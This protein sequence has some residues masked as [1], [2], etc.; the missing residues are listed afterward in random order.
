MVKALAVTKEK[1]NATKAIVA[2]CALGWNLAETASTP[3]YYE[4]EA[5]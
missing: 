2:R 3:K 1:M 5:N 4:V